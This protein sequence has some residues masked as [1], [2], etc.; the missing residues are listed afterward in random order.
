MRIAPA[1]AAMI[2]SAFVS[3]DAQAPV[4]VPDKPLNPEAGRILQLKEDLRITDESGEFFLKY[5]SYLKVAPDGSLYFYD[6]DQLIHVDAKGK[7]MANLYRKGQGPGELNYVSGLEALPDGVI[8]HSNDSS[9][10]VRF[11]SRDKLVSDISLQSLG[12]RW[13]FI[14]QAGDRLLG[15]QMHWPEP[16]ATAG[17]K[18]MEVALVSIAHD[19]SGARRLAAFPVRM[20][21]A[22]GAIKWDAFFG[23]PLSSRRF[24]VSHTKDYSIK[25]LDLQKP[26]RL[27]VL[28][29]KYKKVPAPPKEKR[30]AII[31]SD[32]TRHELPG[33]EFADDITAIYSYKDVLWVQ[34]SIKDPDK[35]IL[36]DVFDAE[37]RYLD[38]FYLKTPGRLLNIQGDS[39][40]IRESA[41]DD[42]LRIV[43][44]KVVG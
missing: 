20:I 39:L 10:L 37:G 19:G 38:A 3:A 1:A 41:P 26:D 7:F 14:G 4:H 8:V 11:D 29:R 40:F 9:K 33:A 24:A 2:L 30:G 43:R 44:Y 12:D 25:I 13:D 17:V 22:G 28:N 36:F 6:Q 18:T 21:R 16:G 23:V 5:P 15:W 35:G 31:S 42:T 34:T 27:L 32:G